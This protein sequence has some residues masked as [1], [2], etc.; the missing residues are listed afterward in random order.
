MTRIPPRIPRRNRLSPL[1][2]C[3]LS[4][5]CSRAPSINII[6]SF[7]PVWMLC[8][9]IAVVIAF[10]VRALLVRFKLETEVGP[11]ALFYPSVVVLS[12]CVL[13]LIFYR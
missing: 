5:G 13:W 10:V 11:V 9:I 1:L 12:A 7:F 6:G 3:L 2:L 4:T 8:A